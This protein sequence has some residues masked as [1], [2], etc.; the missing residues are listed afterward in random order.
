MEWVALSP[1]PEP[2]DLD[3]IRP[4]ALLLEQGQRVHAERFGGE[5]GLIPATFEL[6]YLT[7][8]SPSPDQQKPLRPGS[9]AGRLADALGVPELSAGEKAGKGS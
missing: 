7:G 2:L 5:D 4:P 8:W 3:E 1:K 9:A 6:V